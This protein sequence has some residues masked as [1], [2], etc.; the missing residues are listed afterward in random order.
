MYHLPRLCWMLSTVDQFQIY[1]SIRALRW[2]IVLQMSDNFE[3][4]EDVNMQ[5]WYK[6]MKCYDLMPCLNKGHCSLVSHPDPASAKEIN[7]VRSKWKTSCHQ[8]LGVDHISRLQFCLSLFW[9]KGQR[10]CV[11]AWNFT[12]YLLWCN[13]RKYHGKFQA[14]LFV[15]IVV[16]SPGAWNG[17][18]PICLARLGVAWPACPGIKFQHQHSDSDYTYV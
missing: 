8:T 1:L 13:I 4:V 2:K 16:L 11:R 12:C 15:V 14:P 10:H 6:L 5:I 17:D 9:L 3:E 7:G 18:G